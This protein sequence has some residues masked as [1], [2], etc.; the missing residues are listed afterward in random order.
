MQKFS[1]EYAVEKIVQDDARYAA[2]GY[3]FLREALDFT[4][5]ALAATP[6]RQHTK[7]KGHVDGG[8]LLDGFRSLAL[9]RFGPMAV[10]VLNE[11]GIN[12]TADV[13]EMVFNLIDAEVFGKT[14]SDT[15]EDFVGVYD[16]HEA[17]DQPFLPRQQARGSSRD[18]NLP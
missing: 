3:N 8:Q 12:C 17:F 15:R 1:F 14:A 4:I 13:G 18:G 7:T 6:A 2:S 10:T 5:S 9:E 11:W 16:F